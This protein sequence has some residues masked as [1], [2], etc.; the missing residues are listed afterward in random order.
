[1]HGLLFDLRYALRGLRRT[2]VFTVVVLL[3]LALGI[4]ANSAIF[5]VV[6]T[7]L[8]KPLPYREPERLVTV[9]HDYPALKLEAPVTA[10]GFREYRDRI[11][12]FEYVAVQAGW[13]ANLTG[14]GEP[15]RI[16][17]NRVT[18]QFF[19]VLGVPPML[20]RPFL[21]TEDEPGNDKVVILSHGLW[22]RM[23]G[24]DPAVLGRKISLNGEPYDVVGVMPASFLDPW[25]RNTE[26][27]APLAFTPAQLQSRNEYLALTARLRAGVTIEQ[28]QAEL[29]AHVANVRQDDPA[30]FSSFGLLA[31]P[32]V[33]VLT[34]NVRTPLLVLLGAAGF[35]LLIACANVANLFLVRAAG[36]QKEIALRTALGAQRRSIVR[37]LLV[38]S[39]LLSTA[40]G[41]LGLLLAWTSIRLLA[42]FNPG[43]IP[44]IEEL[45]IDTRGML[46]TAIVAL[47]TGTLFGVYPALRSTAA[48]LHDRLKEGGR[49]GTGDRG[50]QVVRRTLVIAEVA[51][52]LALLV[53]GGLLLRSFAR[54]SNV[55]PGFDARNLLTFAVSLPV[56]RY[57][58]DAARRAFYNEALTR[59]A[60]LP[61]VQHVAAA[62][63]LPFSGGWST[64]SFNVEG[65]PVADDEVS[66]WGDQRIVSPGYFETMGAPLLAGRFFDETDREGAVRVVIVDDEF[67]KRF[68]KPGESAIGRRIWFG[69]RIPNDST[70]FLTIVGVVGHARHEGL[71]AD[72]RVQVYR[73]LG[74]VGGLGGGPIVVRTAGDPIHMVSAVRSAI[75]QV[76]RDMPLAQIRTMEEMIGD[77]M[78]QRRLSTVLLGVFAGI[79]LLLA[80]IG[81]YGVMSY[82]VSQRSREL[83]IRM[84]LGASRDGV[85]RLVLRQGMTM[86]LIGVSVGLVGAFA[87]TRVIASQLYGVKPTDPATFIA[88]TVTLSLV[89]LIASLLPAMRATRVDPMVALRE[90]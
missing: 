11:R 37:Q 88:V 54:L 60:A 31:K 8:L 24:R 90:E 58:D 9:F 7:V 33:T 19:A 16:A 78:G 27:W 12:A 63:V 22:N 20:G 68:Y 6:N 84:A 73:P 65:Y 46:F 74:Q 25:N 76:D 28:A 61:G 50:G 56:A 47:V 77:S 80:S 64:G 3:T 51:L 30:R 18:S 66:P 39:T 15:E 23:F 72:L 43:N 4:G 32:V 62:S 70:P 82:T 86:A 85:L 29:S 52:A 5:S 79:A 75:H 36:R 40:G 42:G 71:D 38:E 13:N 69:G 59:I 67:V 89:A 2:P 17:A 45:S 14:A 34:G 26:L 21:D 87:L 57:P 35:V 41:V 44:R 83:G 49:S 81:I 1:M 55:D 10:P 53:G 48:N